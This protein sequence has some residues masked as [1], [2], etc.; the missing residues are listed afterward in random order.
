MPAGMSMI[1]PPRAR[2]LALTVHIGISV[3]W[4]GALAAYM[5]L[6]LTAAMARDAWTLRAAYL[7][8][9][10]IVRCVI[11][12]L[13]LGALVSGLVVSLGTRWGLF[14]HYWVIISFLLTSVAVAVL[15][16]EVPVVSQLA[17][18]A[19]DATTSDAELAALGSTLVHS[20]G[21]LVVLLVVLMLNMYKPKGM[22]RYGWRKHQQHRR[23]DGWRRTPV[24]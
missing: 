2:K 23:S 19:A 22:T 12:P 24:R 16:F 7:G 17:A 10:V 9:D 20:V 5:A 13:A 18:V 11:V 3:G 8:M 6:D 4:L 15:L 1:M 21:G 14:R